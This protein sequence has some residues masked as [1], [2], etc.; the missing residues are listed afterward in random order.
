MRDW[1]CIAIMAFCFTAFEAMAESVPVDLNEL[2][3]D[4]REVLDPLTDQRLI[5]G[6]FLTLHRS[7]ETLLEIS[8]GS[9]QMTNCSLSH[10]NRPF[11]P[12]HP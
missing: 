4:I 12:S 3:R 7:G 8:E 5:P 10:R 2:E 1:L 9:S 6:Y 11:I